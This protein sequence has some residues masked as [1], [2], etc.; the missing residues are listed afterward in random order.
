MQGSKRTR[1]GRLCLNLPVLLSIQLL[2]LLRCITFDTQL[3]SY[4]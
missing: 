1:T 2:K 3:Q 4:T